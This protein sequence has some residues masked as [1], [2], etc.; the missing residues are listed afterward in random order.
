MVETKV[1]ARPRLSMTGR[2]KHLLREQGMIPAVVYGK[3]ITSQPIEVEAKALQSAIQS[4]GRNALI[5]LVLKGEQGDI[6][7]VV[8]LKEIQ[9]DPIKQ[10]LVHVDLCKISLKDKLHTMISVALKGEARGFVNG[11]IIQAGAREIEVEC[12]PEK[13]PESIQ[14]DISSM[15]I[16]DHLTVA[17]LGET[18]EYKILTDPETVLVTLITTRMAE[19]D[20]AAAPSP[21]ATETS[22]AA[23]KTGAKGE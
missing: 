19:A 7:Y 1:N 2:H 21:A 14:V 16:G 18:A 20:V 8:M 10:N 23:E 15:D 4:K 3:G 13:I 17:D 12:M 22:T 5:D 6:K 9:R 11:G